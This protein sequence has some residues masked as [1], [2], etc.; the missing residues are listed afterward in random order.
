MDINAISGVAITELIKEPLGKLYDQFQGIS[1]ITRAQF[2]GAFSRYCKMTFLR[3]T[4]VRTLYSTQEPVNI[5]EIYVQPRFELRNVLE[6]RRAKSISDVDLS[7]KFTK[8][9]R[10]IVKGNGGSGKT[11]F[12]KKLW[13]KRFNNP[14]GRLPILIELRRLNDMQTPD[15]MTLCRSELQADI[16]FQETA[17]EKLCEMGSFEFILDGFDEITKT[18]RGNIT[19]QILDIANRYPQCPILVSGRDD[20]R[21]MAW[22]PFKTYS[23]S[24]LSRAEAVE[25]VNR[26]PFESKI[27]RDFADLIDEEYYNQHRSFLSNPLL[28]VMMLMTYRRN[29]TVS[30][31]I[32]EFYKDAFQTLL[33]WHDGTK[34]AFERE[35]SLGRDQIRPVFSTFCLSSYYDSV[36]EFDD[37]SVRLYIRKALRYHRIEADIDGVLQDFCETINL[38]QKD[39][40]YYV[41]VHRSFQEYFAAECAMHVVSGKTSQFLNDFVGRTRDTTFRMCFEIHPELVFDFYLEERISEYQ[42]SELCAKVRSRAPRALLATVF[43]FVELEFVSIDGRLMA[44]SLRADTTEM[45]EHLQLLELVS[46]LRTPTVERLGMSLVDTVQFRCLRFFE[47][48]MDTFGRVKKG[49]G[50]FVRVQFSDS[51]SFLLSNLSE[52]S[53]NDSRIRRFERN[54]LADF[55]NFIASTK[56]TL[57][58]GCREADKLVAEMVAG[59]AARKDSIDSILGIGSDS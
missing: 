57:L 51:S 8:C 16:V 47:R 34:D 21:F 24:P 48:H 12:L 49:A 54:A 5:E 4:H 22:G 9:E 13:L 10:L 43:H 29:G 39:G 11:V 23:V 45:R 25:L 36:Y 41:F 18:K 27:K 50:F 26:I 7:F 2:E 19:S 31:K 1:S 42:E 55:P 28:A 56:K 30:D 37:D 46:D 53:S 6:T 3:C 35:R 44:S 33:S 52:L 59:R 20:D 15:I 58:A 38:L 32:T 14:L 17:F 40:L